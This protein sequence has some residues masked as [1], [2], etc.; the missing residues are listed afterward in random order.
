MSIWGTLAGIAS[1]FIPGVGPIIAPLVGGAVNSLTSGSGVSGPNGGLTG[2]GGPGGTTPGQANSLASQ[3]LFNSQLS[4]G[5]GKTA[6]DM[7]ISN[8][9]GASDTLSQPRN[10]FQS[11][12]NGDRANTTQ[13]LAPQIAQIQQ[14]LN[15]RLAAGSTLNAR[16]GGRA[17][18]LF[19]APSTATTAINNLYDTARPAAATALSDIATRQGALGSSLLGNAGQFYGNANTANSLGLNNQL[20]ANKLSFDQSKATGSGLSNILT[21]LKGT[22]WGS[23]FKKTPAA[24]PLPS[25]SPRFDP[26]NLIT[27]TW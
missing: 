16:G 27:G 25:Q 6:G 22:D 17:S 14:M 15:Q 9:Q 18:S 5:F 8:F 26:N 2:G 7:G 19:D 11:I 1:S 24:A 21:G 20:D 10:Y 13:T 12:L 3:N 4:A 23:L